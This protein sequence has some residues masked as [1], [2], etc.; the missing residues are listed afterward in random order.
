V[1]NRH[2]R[3]LAIAAQ[4]TILPHGNRTFP[5]GRGT[6]APRFPEADLDGVWL[7]EGDFATGIGCAVRFP[8]WDSTRP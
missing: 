6:S 1:G 5:N 7:W 8:V 2:A 4:D 3:R